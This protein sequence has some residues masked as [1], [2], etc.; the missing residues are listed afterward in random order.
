MSDVYICVIYLGLKSEHTIYVYLLPSF[1]T[2]QWMWLMRRV[3]V[4]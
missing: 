2:L 4:S 1:V 3:F